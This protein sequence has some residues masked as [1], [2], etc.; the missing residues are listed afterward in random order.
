MRRYT[1]VDA[2]TTALLGA[3]GVLTACG[4]SVT[5]QGAPPGD[6]GGT[7]SDP[8]PPDATTPVPED[9]GTTPQPQPL[10]LPPPLPL[11]AGISPPASCSKHPCTSPT[12]IVVAGVDTGFDTC[13]GGTIRRRAIV[14]CPSTLPRAGGGS[15]SAGDSGAFMNCT[16][17]SDCTMSPDGHC[18]L[19]NPAPNPGFSAQC[20]CNY[21]C[22]NDSDCTGGSICLCGDP[23][24]TCVPSECATGS[25]CLPGCDC[26]RPALFGSFACQTPED[27]C[28]SDP[29]CVGA[30]SSWDGGVPF[31]GCSG[32]A[33]ECA[34]ESYAVNWS[35]SAP[36]GFTCQ[37]HVTCVTGRPFLVH[38]SE[39]MAGCI[40]R[41]DWRAD[42]APDTRSCT[43]SQRSRAAAHWAKV[44]AMEH[45]SIAAFARFTLHLLSLGAPAELVTLSQ[46]AMG[47][48]TEHA[49][50][51]YGLASSYAD[52]PLGPGALAIHGSLDAS[53]TDEIVATL[54][55]EGC[56][57]ETLAAI[58]ARDALEHDLDPA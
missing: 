19:N 14:S 45:A 41:P 46:Q 30:R 40:V 28:Y 55:R 27:T 56:I 16:S 58:E 11:D 21:G 42:L 2:V 18:E 52:L 37:P 39:R 7:R 34:P 15:C 26:A 31:G 4:G 51:A 24:G 29:D 33:L 5:F 23:V 50:L 8:G 35:T 38:G 47:D 36:A 48:E 25:G 10:P 32:S 57:G 6:D 9:A 3:L 20:L 1:S 44:G 12:P 17:D 53:T 43:D 22:R 54:L 49:R 13:A